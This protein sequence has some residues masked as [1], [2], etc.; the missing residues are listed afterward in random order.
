MAAP[1][2]VEE[3]KFKLIAPFGPLRLNLHIAY[4]FFKWP[5]IKAENMK[6]V[7]GKGGWVTCKLH[8]HVNLNVNCIIAKSCATFGLSS[9]RCL[10]YIYISPSFLSQAA[11]HGGKM[12]PSRNRKLCRLPRHKITT[13][14]GSDWPLTSR[15]W[16]NGNQRAIIPSPYEYQRYSRL[17]ASG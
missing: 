17:R 5:F 2:T 1:W 8:V 9:R 11:R 12:I 10:I 6:E 14:I 13:A 3:S 4:C 16:S 15:G 7:R